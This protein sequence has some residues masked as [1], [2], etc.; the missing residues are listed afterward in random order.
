MAHLSVDVPDNLEAELETYMEAED[1]DLDT[2]VTTILEDQLEK[3]R[4]E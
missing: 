3:W 4:D 2:A 1:V